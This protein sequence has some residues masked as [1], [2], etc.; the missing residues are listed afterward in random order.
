MELK[1]A[2]RILDD[3]S[4]AYPVAG[5]S[6]GDAIIACREA[7]RQ[8]LIGDLRTCDNCGQPDIACKHCTMLSAWKE[9]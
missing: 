6:V 8:S 4:P 3:L 2:L 7:A 9:N 1:E 5:T